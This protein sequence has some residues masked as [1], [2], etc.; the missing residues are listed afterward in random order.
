MYFFKAALGDRCLFSDVIDMI[1]FGPSYWLIWKLKPMSQ[2][3]QFNDTD[4]PD[5]VY[6]RWESSLM[7]YLKGL[8]PSNN[9]N[10]YALM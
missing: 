4:G 5:R 8:Y 3:S 2:L 7:I 6:C 10:N 9:F 1:S